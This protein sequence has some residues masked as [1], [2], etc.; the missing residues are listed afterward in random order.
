MSA[1]PSYFK[2]G[3]FVIVATSILVG[4]VI[5]LG[6]GALLE[7]K[8]HIETYMS[9][10]VEGLTVGSAVK[11][12]G[13][14]IGSVDEITFARFKYEPDYVDQGLMGGFV[15][16][17]MALD[18]RKY[19]DASRE[20]WERWLPKARDNGLRVRVASSGIT[21]PAYL[22]AVFL[23]PKEFPAPPLRWTPPPMYVPSAPSTTQVLLGAVESIARKLEDIDYSRV[24]T[25]FD[26]F[27]TTLDDKIGRL[28]AGQINDDVIALI[29]DLRTKVG[30]V[31]AKRL[32][33]EAVALLEEVRASN[34]R[35]REILDDPDVDPA[36]A[37]LRA[38]LE[39][40]KSA[41]AR[42]DEILDDPQ[43]REII[44][45]LDQTSAELPPAVRDVRRVVREIDRLV[46]TQ[47]STIEAILDELQRALE[48]VDTIT[49]DAT[50]NPSRLL[51]GDPPP[52]TTPGGNK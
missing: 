28:D 2:L 46:A 4:G 50:R 26:E 43:V 36:I 18:A 37:D 34:D 23:D 8:I 1:Q 35:L 33:D 3:L 25:N 19:K 32:N 7:E 16:V 11:Y 10:S 29:E 12:M 9:Q 42:L 38:T 51:F 48:N 6:A 21:G 17:D 40:S 5:V 31:D 13:V 49:D 41:M 45:R 14:Q 27:I 39:S 30:E 47:R 15:L 52:R 44:D 22:E 20:D 24:A